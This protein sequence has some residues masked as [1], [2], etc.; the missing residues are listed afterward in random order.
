[1]LIAN[2]EL[3]KNKNLLELKGSRLMTQIRLDSMLVSSGGICFMFMCRF[4]ILT[5]PAGCQAG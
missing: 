2:K 3:N 5:I 4:D 1:M